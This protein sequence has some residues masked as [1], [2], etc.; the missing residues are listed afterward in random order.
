MMSTAKNYTRLNQWTILG[1]IGHDGV[2]Y[3][4]AEG[5]ETI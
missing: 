5:I 1:N 4:Q 2:L 3:A